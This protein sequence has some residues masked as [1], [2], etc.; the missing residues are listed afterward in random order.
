MFLLVKQTL[1][2]YTYVCR[3]AERERRI[4]VRCT[5]IFGGALASAFCPARNTY[6]VTVGCF[7]VLP[8]VSIA[9]G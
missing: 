2:G 9:H 3:Y 4:H 5:K 6:I 8:A 1:D 7:L